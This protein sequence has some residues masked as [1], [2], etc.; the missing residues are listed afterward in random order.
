MGTYKNKALGIYFPINDDTAEHIHE[1]EAELGYKC[2]C[3]AQ[4]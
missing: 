3:G 4:L 1:Y 2:A